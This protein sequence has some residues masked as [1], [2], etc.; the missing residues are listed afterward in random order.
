[1]FIKSKALLRKHC[2]TLGFSL[3]LLSIVLF[4]MAYGYVTGRFQLINETSQA[5]WLL[6]IP[7]VLFYALVYHFLMG[8]LKASSASSAEYRRFRVKLVVYIGLF[9]IVVVHNPL[10][11]IG[12]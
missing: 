6:S 2:W 3:L 11:W 1:M 8:R 10:R 12:G 9:E 7:R 4:M 5:R